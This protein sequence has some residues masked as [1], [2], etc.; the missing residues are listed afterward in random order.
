MSRTILLVGAPTFEHVRADNDSQDRESMAIEE[1]ARSECKIKDWRLCLRATLSTWSQDLSNSNDSIKLPAATTDATLYTACSN[2]PGPEW[3]LLPLHQGHLTTNL[4]QRSWLRTPYGESIKRRK[5]GHS[6]FLGLGEHDEREANPSDDEEEEELSFLTVTS[7]T[8]VEEDDY[9][10]HSFAIHTSTAHKDADVRTESDAGTES[11]ALPSSPLQRP[12]TGQGRR[13][14]PFQIKPTPLAALST[15]DQIRRANPAT[16]TAHLVVGLIS[17]QEPRRLQVRRTGRAVDLV[18]VVVGDETGAGFVISLWLDVDDNESQSKS[19]AKGDLRDELRD[20]RTGD[21]LLMQNVALAV[22]RNRV[23]GQS[24]GRGRTGWKGRTSVRLLWR[25][26]G[27]GGEFVRRMKSRDAGHVIH[28][29]DDIADV[30][31]QGGAPSALQQR[32][33]IVRDWV[34]RFVAVP[35]GGAPQGLL[36]A[37][38]KEG[39]VEGRKRRPNGRGQQ[40]D[41]L[42]PDDTQ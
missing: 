29:A 5:L 2:S 6:S 20:V 17:I 37:K 15:A 32:M 18:E 12:R 3:R 28:E 4:T 36:R 11:S 33:R 31:V 34:L 10:E 25:G 13:L 8:S 27:G 41:Q 39:K 21:V 38:G 26:G 16:I 42:P 7:A 19:P 14:L 24:L 35:A 30:D 40:V 9:L 1:D 22:F 23:H